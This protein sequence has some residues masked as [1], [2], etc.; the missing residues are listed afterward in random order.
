MYWAVL[1]TLEITKVSDILVGE[2]GNEK[3]KL[4]EAPGNF[5]G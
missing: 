3:H 2:M 1:E 5:K 4:T